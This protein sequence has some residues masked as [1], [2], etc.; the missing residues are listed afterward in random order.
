[1]TTVLDFFKKCLHWAL[2]GVAQWIGRQSE[3]QRV[4][5]SIPSAGTCLGWGCVRDNQLIFLSLP[6]PLSNKV[7]TKKGRSCFGVISRLFLAK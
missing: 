2:A 1:M 3:N 7:F 4:L 5:D 6:C